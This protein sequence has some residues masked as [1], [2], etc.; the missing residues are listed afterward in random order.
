M[1]KTFQSEDVDSVETASLINQ[2][3]QNMHRIQK[4]EFEQLP[5][6]KRFFER[7]EEKDWKH[8]F[9]DVIITHFEQGRETAKNIKVS[10]VT[11]ISDAIES[12]LENESLSAS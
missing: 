10:W 9:Q 4:K 2:T 5:T 1:S 7:V 6:V 11:L 12:W 8:T 3:K